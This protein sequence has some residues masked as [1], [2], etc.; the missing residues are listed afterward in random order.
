VWLEPDEWLGSVGAEGFGP[1]LVANQPKARLHSELDVG[2]HSQSVKIAGR[3]AV[4]MHPSDAQ[5]KAS[6]SARTS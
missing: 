6:S 4:R 1:Q 5:G 2:A 3:E